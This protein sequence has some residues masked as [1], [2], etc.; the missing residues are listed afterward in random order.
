MLNR[1]PLPVQIGQHVLP[2]IFRLQRRPL[3][4]L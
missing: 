4:A 2:N 1:L 3:G